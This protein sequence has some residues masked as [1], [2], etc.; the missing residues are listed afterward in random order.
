MDFEK[1]HCL[2]E[3][4]CKVWLFC[5]TPKKVLNSDPI[6]YELCMLFLMEDCLVL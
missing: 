4:S 5:E 2:S 3:D 1:G 6:C